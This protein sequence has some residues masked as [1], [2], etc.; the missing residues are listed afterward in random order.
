[1][2]TLTL[3]DNID[4][5]RITEFWNRLL[6]SLRKYGI[7]FAYVW[8]KEF[9]IKGRRHLH[10]LLDKYVKKSLIRRLWYAATEQTSYLVKINHRPIR[11][12]AGYVSKYVTKGIQHEKRYK[13]KERRYS[14]SR[15]FNYVKAVKSLEWGFELDFGAFLTGTTN[16]Y[17][18]AT[19]ELHKTL[20]RYQELKNGKGGDLDVPHD[21]RHH[22]TQ[23]VC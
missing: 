17:P 14:F 5:T 4:D 3:A 23:D 22:V 1:M 9:T 13:H 16:P 19:L 18:A 12:A 21:I 10:V 20:K 8:F 15:A 6:A 11:T 7:K 2:L